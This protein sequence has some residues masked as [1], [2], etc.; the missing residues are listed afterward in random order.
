MKLYPAPMFRKIVHSRVSN[1][2]FQE[3]RSDCRKRMNGLVRTMVALILILL[4]AALVVVFFPSLQRGIGAIAAG[5][6]VMTIERGV[7]W[8]VQRQRLMKLERKAE[9]GFPDE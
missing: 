4:S 8:V 2:S 7:E 1:E 9:N 6:L 3:M 5:A